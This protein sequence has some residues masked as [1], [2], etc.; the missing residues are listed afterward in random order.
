MDWKKAKAKHLRLGARGEKVAVKLVNEFGLMVLGTNYRIRNGEIDIIALDDET[1]C[2]IEVKTRQNR[3]DSF[4]ERPSDAV[5][6]HK[7][8][9]LS[10]AAKDYLYHRGYPKLL[11]RFDVIEVV[12]DGLFLKSIKW[13]PHF[14]KMEYDYQDGFDFE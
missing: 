7:K 11:H 9:R 6:F 8:K 14:F 5:G 4:L 12:F 10:R 3:L 2:F 13:I 1:I